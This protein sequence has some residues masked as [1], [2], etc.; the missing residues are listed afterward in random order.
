MCGFC[1]YVN[2]KEK[3]KEEIKKM[4]DAI[5]HRGPDD[6]NYYIDSDIAMGFRRLSIIDLKGGR[7][8]MSNEDDSMVIT[9]NG[10]I[11]NFKSIKEDLISKGHIF[12]TNADTEVILH[13]Y[14]EYGENILSQLRGMFG[15]VIW[16]KNKKELFGARDHFGQKPFYY[17][18]MNNTFM[19]GSEIKSFLYNSDFIKEV[20]KDSLKPYLTFQTSVLEETF[21]K[22]VYKLLPGHYFK[23][24]LESNEF[25]TKK[26]YQIVFDAKS[27]DFDSLVKKIDDAITSSIDTHMIS[28]VEI[29]SYLS[30]GI[31]SSYVVSYLKPDKT[32]SV[33]FDYK[34]FNEVPFA[35][36]LSDMLHIENIN[37]LIDSDDFFNVIDKVQYYADEPTANLSAVPLYFLSDLA[38]KH[39]KVVLSGEGADELFGGYTFYKEDDLLLKYRKLPKFL[40][41]AVKGIVSPLPDFHGKNFLTKG[42]SRIE[43]YYVGN[44]FV[45]DNKDA[46]KVLSSKYQSKVKFQDITKPYY[47]EVKDKDDLT[48]MQYLDMHFWLPNDILLKADKMAMAN[49][50]ELRVPILD[51]EVFAL[52]STI[53]S[54]YKLSHGTTKYILRKAASSRIPEEWYKRPKKGFP[55]PIIKWFREEKYYNLA[56]EIFNA[57]FTSEFFNVKEINKMLDEHYSGK[58]NH[59]RKIWTVYVFLVW[60]K[61]FFIDFEKGIA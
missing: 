23:Y 49:S 52:A 17:C 43:D 53:P 22:G 36:D 27:E 32:F 40:R 41:K 24:N 16:D 33:G 28:D 3:K 45:F 18:N 30:G 11:Y 8:P 13:G 29:G 4:T 57:D 35:K 56:K 5:S 60:Y 54:E 20:N 59:C 51:K 25:F 34:N 47:D 55:V 46:N 26:Y 58:K 6:E 31:D 42:G 50:L 7:Q 44:A 12:K 38:S 21:F 19:Y 1:G 14:E 2:K 39:V 10:E 61:T 9:F 15:F 48:K 37:E